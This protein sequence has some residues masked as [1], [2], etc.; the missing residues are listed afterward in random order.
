MHDFDNDPTDRQ[1]ITVTILVLVLLLG[2]AFVVRA[3]LG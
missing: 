1:T 2:A 3:C